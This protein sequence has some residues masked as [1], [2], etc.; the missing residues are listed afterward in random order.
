MI[1]P[2]IDNTVSFIKFDINQ[3][4][5]S[6]RFLLNEKYLKNIQNKLHLSNQSLLINNYKQEISIDSETKNKKR[7]F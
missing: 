2:K 3:L 7:K 1:L 4:N 6:N 5:H